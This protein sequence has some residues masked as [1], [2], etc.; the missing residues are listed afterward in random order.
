MAWSGRQRTL[1]PVLSDDLLL[2][3]KNGFQVYVSTIRTV[4]VLNASLMMQQAFVFQSTPLGRAQQA[5]EQDMDMAAMLSLDVDRTIS[6]IVVMGA[7]L[8]AGA[9]LTETPYTARST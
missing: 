3:D 1:P 6:L 9:G 2:T 4:A 7:A 8:A 5:C